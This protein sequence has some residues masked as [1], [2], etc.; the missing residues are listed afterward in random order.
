MSESGEDKSG[1]R[2]VPDG[3]KEAIEGAFAATG[4]TRAQAQDLTEKTRSRAQGLVDEV[5]KRGSDARDTLE[6]LRLVSRDEMRQ[7]EEKIDDISS[8]LA[9]L[10]QKSKSQ[11]EG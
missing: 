9:E 7:L 8:R 3:L 1:A 5:S 11:P 6:G 2:S 4:R 10:E